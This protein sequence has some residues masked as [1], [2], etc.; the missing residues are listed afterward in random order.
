MVAMKIQEY[1]EFIKMK[2]GK[3]YNP[4]DIKLLAKRIKT[5]MLV[6]RF[7]KTHAWNIPRRMHLI[8]RIFPNG[9]YKTVFFEPTI[10]TEYGINVTYGKN[11]YMNFDCTL[12][13][14]APITI[15]DNVMFGPRVV[16]ATPMH[17]LVAEERMMKDYGDGLMVHDLEYAKPITIGNN[18]W[19]ASHVTICG[20]VT[21]GDN[22][23]I[24]AGSVVTKDIPS[25]VLAV[26]V[27]CKVVREITEADKLNVTEKY[28]GKKD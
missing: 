1:K 25:N 24:G 15:G 9:P 22:V 3:L 26:G 20:G 6:D 23:V 16:V 8:K 4:N 13:D 27:P 17:P 5:R 14:V 21:I 12:L 28:Y 7:N 10:K 18:V 19:I 11:F 2:N